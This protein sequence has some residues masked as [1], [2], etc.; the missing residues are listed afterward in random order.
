M[1]TKTTETLLNEGLSNVEAYLASLVTSD[2]Q[3]LY[4]ASQH[5]LTSGG[6]RVRP[7]LLLL[8]YLAAGGQNIEEAIPLA[9]AVETLHTATLVHDDINDHSDTRRG[10]VSVPSRWGRTFALLTGDYLFAKVYELMSPYGSPYNEIMSN[11]SVRLVE[12]ETLQA[13]AAKSGEMDR[14]TYKKIISRKTASLFEAA[15]HVGAQLGGATE[16]EIEALAD[17]GYNLGLTF[18]IVDDILDIVGDPEKLGKPVGID[19]IQNRGVMMVQ[20]GGPAVAEAENTATS[21]RSVQAVLE[22]DPVQRM[23]HDLR[24]SG[25]V[26]IARMQAREVANR[27]RTALEQLPD[28]E[29]REMLYELV[30]LVMERD[31]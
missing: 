26:E 11:A 7:Q 25:A 21:T 10:K 14:E 12:G 13:L 20:N 17:Y 27:A 15:A 18:Q 23:L 29:A 2:V 30:D 6:K 16:T 3:T 5:I 9:T 28:S 24:E 8:S 4:D 19:M 22:D 1:A 31:K